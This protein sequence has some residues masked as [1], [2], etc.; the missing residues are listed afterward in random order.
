MGCFPGPDSGVVLYN[1]CKTCEVEPSS[2]LWSGNNEWLPALKSPLNAAAPCL[3][4]CTPRSAACTGVVFTH[5]ECPLN[6]HYEK[7]QLSRKQ[8][9]L[10]D[11]SVPPTLVQSRLTPFPLQPSSLLHWIP[12]FI[13]C[14]WRMRTPLKM[15]TVSWATSRTFSVSS[16]SRRLL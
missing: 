8:N 11:S 5:P 12:Y 15:L 13:L 16:D 14:W 9:W 1:L 2:A 10:L 3:T 4:V 7:S 6:C